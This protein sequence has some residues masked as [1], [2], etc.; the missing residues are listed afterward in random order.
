MNFSFSWII[1]KLTNFIFQKLK[2][3]TLKRVEGCLTPF[4]SLWLFF[5]FIPYSLFSSLVSISFF[6]SCLLPYFSLSFFLSHQFFVS[7]RYRSFK[8]SYGSERRGNPGKKCQGFNKLKRE[9]I[10]LKIQ[11]YV[12]LVISIL[13]RSGP[14]SAKRSES[15]SFCRDPDQYHG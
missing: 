9:I 6:P 7:K 8:Q 13:W 14:W 5:L 12:K 3:S 15:S 1:L 11:N 2:T 10:I 4:S